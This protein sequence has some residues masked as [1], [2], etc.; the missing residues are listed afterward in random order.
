MPDTLGGESSIPGH[1]LPPRNKAEMVIIRDNKRPVIKI[2]T[3]NEE[4]LVLN[5]EGSKKGEAGGNYKTRSDGPTWRKG[6]IF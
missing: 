4:F 2:I 3:K 6:M 1:F 5:S